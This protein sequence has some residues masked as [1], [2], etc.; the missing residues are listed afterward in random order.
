MPEG[1]SIV[2]LKEKATYL[3]H[4]IVYG[5]SGYADLDMD[6]LVHHKIVD[7]K[8]WGKHFLIC[9]SDFT[10]RIHFGLFGSYQ[11]HEPRKVNPKIAL[12]FNDDSLYF[13]VC[14]VKRL[15]QPL[16][17]VYD[18][19]A[20][21]MGDKWSPAKALKKLEKLGDRQI[22]DVLL[23]QNIF[24]GVGN[25]IK[26]EVLYRCG[27]H[28]ESLVGKIPAAR[29][30]AIV[31]EC[32]AYSFDFLKWKKQNQLSGHYEVYKQEKSRTTGAQV[33]RKDTGKTRR[34]SYFVEK[35]QKCYV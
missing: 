22:C 23:D 32:R 12:H 7:F 29:L 25:I 11:F 4:K 16:E 28:P 15:D 26:N 3:K 33:I 24:A 13:Y 8:S 21:V 10:I 20:D 31:K 14:T 19:A 18:W 2:I 27:V 5:V 17:E 30:K 9:F 35:E 1:P 6:K 34:S